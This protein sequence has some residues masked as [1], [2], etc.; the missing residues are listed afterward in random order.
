MTVLAIEADPA[1][2]AMIRHVACD[3]LQADVT[4][5]DSLERAVRTLHAGTPEVVLVPALLSPADEAD[6]LSAI[7]LLPDAGHVEVLTTPRLKS[8]GAA[9]RR[10][11]PRVAQVGV[12]RL[13]G[14]RRPIGSWRGE[15][16]T[17]LR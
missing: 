17:S 1:Q 16:D 7:R 2:T 5:V 13:I 14:Q 11:A 12:A 15:R 10:K 4:V 6:L 3:M 8:C 9:G